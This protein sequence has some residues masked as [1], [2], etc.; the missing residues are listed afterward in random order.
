MPGPQPERSSSQTSVCLGVAPG[1]ELQQHVELTRDP[2]KRPEPA[3]FDFGARKSLEPDRCDPASTYLEEGRPLAPR[4]FGQRR[5]PSLVPGPGLTECP[6]GNVGYV[7]D[8]RVGRAGNR[9]ENLPPEDGPLA[10]GVSQV[11]LQIHLELRADPTGR[12]ER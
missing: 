9:H 4:A 10:H 5:Q 11:V 12:S 7:R 3:R 6:A 8:G 1:P 2:H